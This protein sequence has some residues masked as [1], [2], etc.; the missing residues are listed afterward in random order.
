M[1]LIDNIKRG[2]EKRQNPRWI[3]TNTLEQ[4]ARTR[5]AVYYYS[6]INEVLIGEVFL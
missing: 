4:L 1:S 5:E 6:S 3:D 2:F